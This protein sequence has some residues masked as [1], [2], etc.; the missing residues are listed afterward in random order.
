MGI[1]KATAEAVKGTLSDSWLEVY[2]ADN[3]DDQTLFTRGVPVR[4][5]ENKKR[6]RDPLDTVSQIGRA[7]V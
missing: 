2:E 7:H 1:I 4:R 3:M 5:G 6:S